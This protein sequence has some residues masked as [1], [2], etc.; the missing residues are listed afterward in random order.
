MSTV[1]HSILTLLG[2]AL[3]FLQVTAADAKSL[4]EHDGSTLYL[5]ASG[6]VRKFFYQVPHPN[7][8]VEPGTLL[9]EGR[10]KGDRYTGTAYKFSKACGPIGYQVSGPVSDGQLRVTLRGKA[11]QRNVSCEIAG[12]T[13]DVL[14][15]SFLRNASDAAAPLTT[16]EKPAGMHFAGDPVA[17][18]MICIR[19]ADAPM[20][21]KLLR[22]V[23]GKASRLVDQ[24]PNCR[25]SSHPAALGVPDGLE[26]WTAETL[27]AGGLSF[28]YAT[29]ASAGSQ[30]LRFAL[31]PEDLLSTPLTAQSLKRV[32][33]DIECK[34]RTRLREHF[35]TVEV[36]R[37][38]GVTY[39]DGFCW[40][41]AVS[42]HTRRSKAFTSAKPG[43]LISDDYWFRAT[44]GI[45]MGY[46]PHR[47]TNSSK[48]EPQLYV[49]TSVYSTDF[50]Q[51]PP[52]ST[53][54]PEQYRDITHYHPGASVD[55]LEKTLMERAAEFLFAPALVCEPGS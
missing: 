40:T 26:A 32:K 30:L 3:G 38:T 55:A 20:A 19:E 5:E 13:N 21:T 43:N 54:E 37:C 45:W 14:V 52:E 17:T 12:Y 4:W 48:M 42:D 29:A 35:E 50:A 16:A 7:L 6:Q 24:D 22:K 47:S 8:G 23:G 34:I 41:V 10:R 2:M 49:H 9:F 31:E 25:D 18:G 51:L 11:P 27:Q 36:G 1:A 44:I 46:Y 15:F 28:T 39:S 53:P 33:Q